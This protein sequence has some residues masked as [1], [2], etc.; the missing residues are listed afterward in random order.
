M[1]GSVLLSFAVVVVDGV[2]VVAMMARTVVETDMV[3]CSAIQS[4]CEV[5]LCQRPKEFCDR[6]Y[7]LHDCRQI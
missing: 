5:V 6:F 3:D 1:D 4:I 2:V 7:G